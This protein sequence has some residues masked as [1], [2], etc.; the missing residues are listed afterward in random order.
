MQQINDYQ[1]IECSRDAMQGWSHFIPT[2]T[3]INYINSLLQVGFHTLDVGSFV[4]PKAIPQMADTQEVL[5]KID[6]SN[7]NTKLLAIVANTRGAE[8]ASSFHQIDYIGFPFSIS[9]TFQQKNTNSTIKQS[10]T[11]LKQIQ[12]ICF[13]TNKKLVVYLSMGFGNP[14]GDIYNIDLLLN[15]ANYMV[16]NKIE[17][18]SIADTV[19]IA[20]PIL[21]SEVLNSL[22]PQ[23]RETTFGVHLH[24]QYNE[25]YSKL[26]AAIDAGC[27]RIDGAL[28]GIGGCPM[29]QNTLVGNMPTEQIINYLRKISKI[30]NN[31]TIINSIALNKS[32]AIANTIF[33]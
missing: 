32:L 18:I 22:I 19:G 26:N 25:Y 29:A 31:E 3:K 6:L 7:T 23:F 16:Q 17:I 10:A 21:V 27:T 20:T 12:E 14:Y 9:E 28:M 11:T 15:W 5:N 1:I 13:K 4:S 33:I 24:C 8:E 2:E 30:P